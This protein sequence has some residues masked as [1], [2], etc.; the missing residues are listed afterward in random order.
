MPFSKIQINAWDFHTPKQKAP[1][2]KISEPRPI[3]S[4]FLR[5]FGSKKRANSLI[6]SSALFFYKVDQIEKKDFLENSWEKF[7]YVLLGIIGLV[8]FQAALS[9]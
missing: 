7:P 4:T 3:I 2:L 9:P 8:A 1:R 6:F 5:I